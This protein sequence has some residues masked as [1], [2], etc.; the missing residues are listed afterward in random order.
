M[1]KYEGQEG[2]R[3]WSAWIM[4][5][6]SCLTNLIAFYGE[7]T[8]S[9]DEGRTV[10]IVYLDFSMAFDLAPVTSPLTNR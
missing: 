9:V 1:E 2:D 10:D 4:E 3:K 8:G 6:K 5:G 7:M